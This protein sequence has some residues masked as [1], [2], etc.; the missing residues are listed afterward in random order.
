MSLA[1]AIHVLSVVI[2]VGGMFFA[3][4]ALR[5][6][7]AVTLDPPMRLRLWVATFQRF[8]PWVWLSIVL[9]LTTGL[10]MMMQ[11]PK[12]P[13]YIH[14]MLGL[15]ILMMIIFMHVYFAAYK[16]LKKA[17][18]AESWPDGGTALGKIRILVGINTLI[19]IITIFVATVGKSLFV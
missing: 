14:M 13:L 18:K 17:V 12:P 2:W 7:A 3:Y 19:G 8:F 1:L 16:K 11:L 9:I 4:N 10:W 5:P 15:G 6:A